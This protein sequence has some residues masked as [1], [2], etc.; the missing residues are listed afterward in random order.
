MLNPAMLKMY[1]ASGNNGELG[2]LAAVRVTV[3]HRGATEILIRHPLQTLIGAQ[4]KPSIKSSLAI[5]SLARS[6]KME[7]GASGMIGLSAHANVVVVPR[8]A[9]GVSL[10]TQIIAGHQLRATPLKSH[11]VERTLARSPLIVSSW[12]GVSGA[13]VLVLALAHGH[14]QGQ[15]VCRAERRAN[16]AKMPRTKSRLAIRSRVELLQ[17]DVLLT[18]TQLIVSLLNGQTGHSALPHAGG[19]SGAMSGE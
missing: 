19:A 3:A 8:N 12:T 9:P 1:P 14:G 11:N 18:C 10:R 2:V 13:L 6:V 5:Q 15:L 16:F 7:H 17:R 4:Q